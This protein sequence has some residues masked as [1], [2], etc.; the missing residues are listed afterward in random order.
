MGQ[1]HL[2]TQ[3]LQIKGVPP[4]HQTAGQYIHRRRADK[5]GYKHIAGVGIQL[6]GRVCLLN[7][8]VQHDHDPIRH[9]HGLRLVMG[10]IHK[11]GTQFPVQLCNACAHFCT[12]LGVQVRQGLVQKEHRRIPHHSTTQRHPL[13][14]PAGQG[15]GSPIQ[16]RGQFQRLCGCPHLAV[17]LRL[18]HSPQLQT[19][20]HILVHR[21]VRVQS[22]ALEHHGNIPILGRQIVH[23][24]VTD[25]Q[26]AAADVLQPGNHTQSGGLAATGRS[27]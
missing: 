2:R 7:L 4:P 5:P 14:L 16:V 9:G 21:H 22:V 27:Y 6:C 23:Y 10:H 18:G 12:Q 25:L 3:H 17:D 8:A 15:A 13:P 19:K 26:G 11:G 24:P 1:S 20:G